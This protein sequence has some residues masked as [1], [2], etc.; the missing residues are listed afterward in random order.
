MKTILY[1][2]TFDPITNGHIN[3][4]ER[5]AK[6]FDKVVICVARSKL[7]APFFSF[8][9]RVDLCIKALSHIQ[10]IQ[11][12]GFTGLIVEQCKKHHAIAVLRGV[13]SMTDFDYELQMA[14][15]NQ[16]LYQQ[17]DTVFLT[18]GNHLAFISSTLVRE[19]ATL[20]GDVSTFVPHIVN[21]ALLARC[22]ALHP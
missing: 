11:V 20:H 1:P 10:N 19:I 15:M 16:A 22:S 8:E 21:D 13:R 9:E 18:P 2:G 7:K 4:V 17:F 3:L 5:A 12:T 6:L 14:G